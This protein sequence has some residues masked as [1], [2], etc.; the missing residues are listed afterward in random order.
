MAKTAQQKLVNLLWD[1]TDDSEEHA[2]T[3]EVLLTLQSQQA[4]EMYKLFWSLGGKY[5]SVLKEVGWSPKT[6]STPSGE[7]NG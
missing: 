7:V 5:R 4:D 2:R 1:L 6:H 3:G